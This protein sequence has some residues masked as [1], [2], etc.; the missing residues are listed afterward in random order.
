MIMPCNKQS[1]NLSAYNNKH[2]F[3]L[4]YESVSWLR[5]LCFGLWIGFRSGLLVSHSDVHAAA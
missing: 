5:Q 3:F 1:P 4:V 2:F